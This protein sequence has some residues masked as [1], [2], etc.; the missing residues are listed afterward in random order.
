MNRTRENTITIMTYLT[1]LTNGR[2]NERTYDR[3]GHAFFLPLQ[4]P[5]SWNA[6]APGLYRLLYL[7]LMKF[8]LLLTS[9]PY[10]SSD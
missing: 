2:M 3:D 4:I 8:V 1:D 5:I 10:I 9:S 6:P 7:Y